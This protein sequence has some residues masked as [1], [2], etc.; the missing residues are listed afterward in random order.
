VKEEGSVRSEERRAAEEVAGGW[1][2][3]RGWVRLAGGAVAMTGWWWDPLRPPTA[4]VA[5]GASTGT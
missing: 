5:G 3:V 4:E 2:R 1:V